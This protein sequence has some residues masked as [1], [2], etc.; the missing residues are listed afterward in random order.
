MLSFLKNLIVN[1]K[2]SG[3]QSVFIVWL[4]CLAAVAIFGNENSGMFMGVFA[5]AGFLIFIAA[6]RS[7]GQE[8]KEEE[9]E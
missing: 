3:Y 4:V 9:E 5:M 6:S 1:L 7:S 8:E 2:S